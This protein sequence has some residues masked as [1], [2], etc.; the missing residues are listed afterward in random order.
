MNL[1]LPS[2]WF[3]FHPAAF[4]VGGSVR[5]YLMGRH[6]VDLDVTI[7][8]D[9]PAYAEA[10]AR[11][12]Q[13]RLVVLGKARFSLYRIVSGMLTIDVTPAKGTDIASDLQDRD[14]TVNGLAC[15]LSDGWILDHVGGLN[16]IRE[17]RIH[18]VS[19]GIFNADPIRLLRAHRLAACLGMRIS[20][21]TRHAIRRHS[22]HIQQSA[23][24]RIWSELQLIFAH[25]YSY[26]QLA[27]MADS[28]L[29]EAVFP[30]LGD[31]RGCLQNHFHQ[32]D[33]WQHTLNAYQ[34]VEA[35]LTHRAGV[36]PSKGHAFV[37]SMTDEMKVLLK[38]AILLHDIGKPQCRMQDASGQTHF[39]GHAA[40]GVHPVRRICRRLRM[41]SR[42]SRWIERAVK[43]HQWPLNLFLSRQKAL[44]NSRAIGRFLRRCGPLTPYVLLQAMADC[45]GKAVRPG[46]NHLEYLDFI[47]KI[48]AVYFEKAS[49]PNRPPLLNGS[50]L[51]AAFALPP[52]PLI[53]K[54]LRRIEEARLSGVIDTRDQALQ[55]VADYMATGVND[56]LHRGWHGF[57]SRGRTDESTSVL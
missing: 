34:A 45:M 12:T 1:F 42:H 31:L 48:M 51:Q 14:F 29:L 52:S 53:G 36:L 10:L 33:V 30:E 32:T 56:Q 23:G 22:R 15:R 54:L 13:G 8:G 43:H 57:S 49:Q 3:L 39:H 2:H 55:L 5:D 17:K 20:R 21:K 35:L 6:P 47:R 28:G 7:V 18:M 41:S 24:E 25:K 4:L 46:G 44:F 27:E 16:D 38:M 50:D 11:K 26:T 37:A 40:M 9:A 19:D